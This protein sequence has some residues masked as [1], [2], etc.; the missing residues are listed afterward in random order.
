[1]SVD[2]LC[3]SD[4]KK[5]VERQL[6]T[7]LNPHGTEHATHEETRNPVDSAHV[8][9]RCAV[10]LRVESASSEFSSEFSGNGDACSKSDGYS[11]SDASWDTSGYSGLSDFFS[12]PK[13]SRPYLQVKKDYPLPLSTPQTGSIL[14]AEFY[15]NGK[16][17]RNLEAA[18]YIKGLTGGLEERAY[19]NL[20]E[21]ALIFPRLSKLGKAVLEIAY[22]LPDTT[23][24]RID[25][26]IAHAKNV[27]YGLKPNVKYPVVV[28]I[29]YEPS[30][31]IAWRFYL[32]LDSLGGLRMTNLTK[33]RI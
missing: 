2:E 25:T 28:I 18:I 29:Y 5:S 22:K 8:V 16:L 12:K 23:E 19:W 24:W 1:L 17:A 7:A 33:I 3:F 11:C 15:N 21:R 26:P 32:T 27:S 9:L 10:G 31:T 20:P 13:I 30:G 4:C 14:H 6:W